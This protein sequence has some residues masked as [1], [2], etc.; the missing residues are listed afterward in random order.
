[1]EPDKVWYQQSAKQLHIAFMKIDFSSDDFKEMLSDNFTESIFQRLAARP[2][3]IDLMQWSIDMQLIEDIM[4]KVS[5]EFSNNLNAIN[6]ELWT[7]HV[8]YSSS[9]YYNAGD[10]HKNQKTTDLKCVFLNKYTNLLTLGTMFLGRWNG[11]KQFT[12]SDYVSFFS[13]MYHTRFGHDIP[14]ILTRPTCK[15][16]LTS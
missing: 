4:A 3:M 10:G 8:K 7:R 9:T 13:C 16:N 11:L 5:F 14:L 6:V 1:M 12:Q 2:W 15:A